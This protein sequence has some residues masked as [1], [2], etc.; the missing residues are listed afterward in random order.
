[1]TLFGE[2]AGGASVD[3]YS[4]AWTEDPI[5]NGFIPQSGSAAMRPPGSSPKP[6][7]E[8]SW[9]RLTN[10]LGC[11]KFKDG[12]KTVDCMRILPATT[13]MKQLI[14]WSGLTSNPMSA[15]TQFGP[16]ADGKVVFSDYAKRIEEGKFIK[17]VST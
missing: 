1:M 4:Y 8:S 14:D 6:A 7:N 5:I 17:R 15:L 16:T 3:F 10:R 13:I 2:S 11:G 9:Y 12:A